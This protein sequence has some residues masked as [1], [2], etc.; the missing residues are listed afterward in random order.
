MPICIKIKDIFG[1]D[2]GS[3]LWK[4]NNS[5]ALALSKVYPEYEWLPWKFEKSPNKYWDNKENQKFFMNWLA[6]QLNIKELNDW[7]KVTLKVTTTN[8]L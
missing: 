2:G 5:L 8:N 1:V 4:H 3:V 6:K 7:Y